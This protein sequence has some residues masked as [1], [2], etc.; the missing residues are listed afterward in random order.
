MRGKLVVKGF[1]TI[2][3]KLFCEANYFNFFSSKNR[4]FVKYISFNVFFSQN[5]FFMKHI[6]FE[7][8]K[9]FEKEL[10]EEFMPVA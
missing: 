9:P 6:K 1:I 4:F 2:Y 10:N 5:S 7:K 3:K 8:R